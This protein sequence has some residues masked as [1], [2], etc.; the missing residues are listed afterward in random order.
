MTLVIGE[1]QLAGVAGMTQRA[2][3]SGAEPNSR[4]E[5]SPLASRSMEMG[6][7]MTLLHHLSLWGPSALDPFE[8][9]YLLASFSLNIS[10][11]SI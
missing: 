2:E 7:L 4:H 1:R 5:G 10:N 9:P 8:S 3:Y 6:F 11:W